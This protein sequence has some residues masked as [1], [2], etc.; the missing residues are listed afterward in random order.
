M[1][2]EVRVATTGRDSRGADL[3]QEIQATLGITSVQQVRTRKV[4]R[5]EGVSRGQAETLAQ[6]LLCDS[7]T[8]TY[9][10]GDGEQR[11]DAMRR[12]EVAYKPGVMNPEA[13]SILKAAHDCGMKELVAADSS[14]EYQVFGAL[15]DDELHQIVD[16]LLVNKTVE[17]VVTEKPTTLLIGNEPGSV[18]IVP[19]TTLADAELEAMSRTRS[20]FLNLEEMRVIQHHF[21]EFHREP[22]DAELETL[23]QTRSEHCG[24][25]TFK[26]RLIVDG[27][28]QPPLITR[29]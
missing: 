17:H 13:A 1:I 2:Y 8:Q 5:L 23:A 24:H 9:T 11:V 25:K 19:I 6:S 15:T 12:I 16:R 14:W 4:Y 21:R 29:L 28:E 27:Q 22:T 18:Q 26:A 20:L 3:L 7:L 10:I